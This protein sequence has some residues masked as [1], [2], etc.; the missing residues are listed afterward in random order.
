MTDFASLGIRIDSTQAR[1]A[2]RDLDQFAKSGGRAEKSA[3]DLGQALRSMKALFAGVIGADVVRRFVE[4]ADAY[5]SMNARLAL[6]TRSTRE[7]TAAQKALFDISQNTRVGLEQTT[8]LFGSLSRSTESLGVSQEQVLRVT[9]TINKALVVSGTSAQGAQAALVQLGQGFAAGALR[10]EELNSVLEQAPRLARAIADGLGVPLGK[11]RELGQQGKL[12]GEQVFTALTKSA[13]GINKEFAR[14]PVTVAQATTQAANSWTVLVGAIDEAT[15]ATQALAQVTQESATFLGQLADEIKRA[16]QGDESVGFLAQA[17]QYVTET[18]KVLWAEVKFVFQ[19]I[20]QEIGAVAAQIRALAT[21][22]IKGFTAISDAVREDAARARK[23]LDAYIA[24][25]LV[26]GR[27]DFSPNNQSDAEARRLGLIPPTS[28]P[29]TPQRTGGSGGGKSKK[30]GI[31]EAQLA[32]DLAAYKRQL[33]EY[34]SAFSTEQAI[35]EARR[36]AGLVS[37][38]AYYAKRRELIEGTAKAE[39]DALVAER[40]RLQQQ[41]L[42]GAE[43]IK[44]NTRIADLESEIARKRKEAT[45]ELKVLSIEQQAA[46]KRVADELDR[47]KQSAEEY[48][49][50]VSRANQREL[51]GIGQGNKAREQ[52]AALGAIDDK[53]QQ[54]LRQ[55]EGELRR[56]EI[57][58]RQFDDYVAVARDTYAKEVDLYKERTAAIEEAQQ[59]WLNGALEALNNYYDEATNKAKHMEETV[60]NALKGL[61]DQFTNLLTGKGFDAKALFESVTG[62]LARNFVQENITGPLAG[63]AKDFLGVN[64]GSTGKLGTQNN[65]MYVKF[66]DPLSIA[67]GATQGGGGGGL[68]SSLL[69]GAA[70]LFG[71]FGNSFAVPLANSMSGD[72]LD[73]LLRLTNNYRGFDSGGYTGNGGKYQPA[74]IVHA[75]EYVIN[76]ESTRNLG[77]S[78]L[79]R[80]NRRGYADGGYVR[81]IV[82]GN[83]QAPSSSAYHYSPTINVDGD[84]DKRT[85]NQLSN[86]LSREQ[87]IAQARMR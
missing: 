66:A 69:G 82:A 67:G 37:E 32:A 63:L 44:N 65:P 61:E 85:A 50:A 23:E 83:L 79:D 53:L 22:D 56:G 19:M 18:V 38:E 11:L 10:G 13:E 20:G 80:L 24:S 3:N 72:A 64:L 60:G 78:F 25:V 36:S 26:I 76:A 4:T 15:G 86:R 29:R 68:L 75:G 14:M 17:F 31:A 87:R 70:S 16:S 9:E 81:P 41:K 21:L 57:N 55:Y 34:T 12:T 2:S 40:N 62:D 54:Q 51:A 33:A 45:T 7:F 46:V 48:L 84:I 30:D 27:L 52:L 28:L 77:L 59:N 39:V 35:L 5:N 58:D 71:G 47:A 73:N 6:V 8:D 42:S 74:G 43:A 1:T 49:A